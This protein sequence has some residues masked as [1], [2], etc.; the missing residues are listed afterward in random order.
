M[1]F[2]KQGIKVNEKTV[3]NLE[4]FD[5]ELNKKK[6][7]RFNKELNELKIRDPKLVFFYAVKDNEK[8]ELLLN[9]G[10][11]N[12]SDNTNILFT[13][14]PMTK[15]I[16]KIENGYILKVIVDI[17]KLSSNKEGIKLFK[18]NKNK[19]VKNTLAES[20][21]VSYSAKYKGKIYPYEILESYK[22]ENSKIIIN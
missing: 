18:S 5:E 14:L 12:L 3:F 19:E 15:I 17:N 10:I 21:I 8:L 13:S 4:G 2:Y 9:R 16:N 7:T 20:L 6:L 11:T 1:E 22:V